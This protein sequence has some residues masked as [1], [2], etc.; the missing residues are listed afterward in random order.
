M[1]YNLKDIFSPKLF[2]TLRHYSRAQFAPLPFG[3]VPEGARWQLPSVY[4]PA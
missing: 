3:K 4:H 2:H 1:N